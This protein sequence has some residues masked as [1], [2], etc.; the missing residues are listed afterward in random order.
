MATDLACLS[1]QMDMHL[2]R[3]CA[4]TEVFRDLETEWRAQASTSGENF[5]E[6]ARPYIDHAR[7]IAS[8]EPPH[9]RYGIFLLRNNAGSY[10][11]L[12]HCNV[13]ELP[14][15]TG[16]TLRVNWVLLA[17]KYDYEDAPPE[18]L[19]KIAAG[20]IKEVVRLS[21]GQI[22]PDF[23]AEHIKIRFGGW[24]DRRFFEGVT[25]TLS[26]FAELQEPGFR[27]NWFHVSVGRG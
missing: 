17:P 9:P 20:L 4:T 22:L 15:T 3:A 1:R 27:G 8:E 7:S 23:V 19:A 2:I 14:R 10:E 25:F 6:F 12:S 21:R 16:R 11:C 18:A 5:D 26:S 24:A 13:A